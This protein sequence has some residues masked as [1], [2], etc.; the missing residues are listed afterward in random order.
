MNLEQDTT[1]DGNASVEQG[2]TK[3]IAQVRGPRDARLSRATQDGISIANDRGSVNV[4]VYYTPFSSSE[5]RKRTKNDRLAHS[6]SR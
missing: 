5:R 2:L 3:V 6:V 4:S 1:A